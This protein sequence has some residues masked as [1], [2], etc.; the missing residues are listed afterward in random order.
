MVRQLRDDPVR[1]AEKSGKR[2]DEGELAAAVRGGTSL[3]MWPS[4]EMYITNICKPF[5]S[6]LEFTSFFQTNDVTTCV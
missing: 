2:F 1:D 6:N 4:S 3:Q 5:Y